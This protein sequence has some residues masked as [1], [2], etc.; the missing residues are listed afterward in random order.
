[1]QVSE[2]NSS[3]P[4]I[5]TRALGIFAKQPLPGRVK[6][7]LCP[8]LSGEQAAELYRVSLIETVESLAGRDF[9]LVLFYA[10]EEAFFQSAFPALP[11]IA[12]AQGGLGERLERAFEA[13]FARG[14]RRAAM[15]GS[16]SP[17]L[18]AHLVEE[19]FAALERASFVTAPAADGGYVLVGQDAVHP[20][21]FRDI[22]WSTPGVL[23]ATRE[24]ARALGIGYREV[25]GWE[26]VDDLPS[27]RRLVERSPASA[28]ARF[29]RRL[30]ARHGW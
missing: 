28:T 2:I 26:D 16:D 13:L 7:R 19:A 27:L 30:L 18:P 14:C 10:G 8:P 6:T 1:M 24:R 21:L 11:R 25:A 4:K 23:A 17:D 5:A 9:D 12:Q 22:P 3:I 20:E 29:G 15:I